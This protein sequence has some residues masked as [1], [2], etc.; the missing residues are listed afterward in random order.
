M[1]PG[2]HQQFDFIFKPRIV[3]KLSFPNLGELSTYS[4]L[5]VTTHS[6]AV[7][8]GGL[9]FH[10]QLHLSWSG[11]AKGCAGTCELAVDLTAT[12]VFSSDQEISEVRNDFKTYL[13]FSLQ[14]LC[15][16]VTV[17]AVFIKKS[18]ITDVNQICTHTWMLKQKG[19]SIENVT[20]LYALKYDTLS[21]DTIS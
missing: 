6:K 9:R 7:C 10:L 1:N 12:T 19:K 15:H 11:I 21:S 20:S 17:L 13:T 14:C 18:L 2:K 4:V 3:G 16:A 5:L 8:V